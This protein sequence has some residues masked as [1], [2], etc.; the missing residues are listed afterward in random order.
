MAIMTTP[1]AT[2]IRERVNKIETTPAIPMVLQPLLNILSLPMDE[3]DVDE[4]VRLVSYDNTI[5]AQCLRV[6]G[7]PLFGLAQPPQ[8]VSAAVVVLGLRRV[9][10]I[11]LTCCMGRAFPSSKSALDSAIYWKHSLGCAM[12]CRKFCEKLGHVDKEKAYVAGLLHDIGFLVNALVLPEKFA[13]AVEMARR[14]QIPLD[15]AEA[16]TMGFTHSET[17]KALAENWGIA[18]DIANA[19]AYHHSV[20]SC[21]EPRDITAVVHLCDLM[22]RMRGM[23]YGYYERQKIDLVSDLAWTLLAAE[24][25]ELDGLDL[26]L[27]TFEMDEAIGEVTELVSTIFGPVAAK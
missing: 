21:P 8:S 1:L 7:S 26:E 19:I 18:P 3:V 13:A 24:H 22:C 2:Y 17:G 11:L 20:E 25:K 10:S 6:A 23:D 12:V 5:A 14:E 4:V 27:F 15:Q 16:A 9:E